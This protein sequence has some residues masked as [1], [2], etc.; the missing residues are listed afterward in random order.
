VK[1]LERNI[2]N[3]WANARDLYKELKLQGDFA[4]EVSFCDPVEQKLLEQSQEVY[5]VDDAYESAVITA[6]NTIRN[7]ADDAKPQLTQAW[8]LDKAK[9]V[10][11]AWLQNNLKRVLAKFGY[12]KKRI[13]HCGDIV[14]V[15]RNGLQSSWR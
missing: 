15:K 4:K 10:P 6:L 14:Y 12:E 1:K 3:I 7:C 11:A 5:I 13:G 8:F 2:E 9:H